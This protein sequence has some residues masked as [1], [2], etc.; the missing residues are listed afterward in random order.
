MKTT[1]KV[2]V[3]NLKPSGIT[4]F[5]TYIAPDGQEFRL[6]ITKDELVERI[7]VDD[8]PEEIDKLIEDLCVDDYNYRLAKEHLE[9]GSKKA[10][11]YRQVFDYL[12]QPIEVQVTGIGHGDLDWRFHYHGQWYPLTIHFGYA[13]AVAGRKIYDENGLTQEAIETIKKRTFAEVER[14]RKGELIDLYLK[15]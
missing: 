9:E 15:T 11:G 3:L 12:G 13:S 10:L 2:W 1:K 5:I 7:D 14:I 6:K 4:I 8:Q